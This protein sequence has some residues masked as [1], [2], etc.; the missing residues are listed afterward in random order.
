MR[1]VT[2]EALPRLAAYR[3]EPGHLCAPLAVS[4]LTMDLRDRC[5]SSHYAIG[6]WPSVVWKLFAASVAEVRADRCHIRW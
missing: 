2:D 4:F 5:E 1:P 3:P 6:R